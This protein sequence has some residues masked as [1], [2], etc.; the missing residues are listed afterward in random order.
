M[1]WA[2]LAEVLTEGIGS[3]PSAL[4]EEWAARRRRLAFD[5]AAAGHVDAAGHWSPA[6]RPPNRTRP[7]HSRPVPPAPSLQFREANS[8]PKASHERFRE[9]RMRAVA[10]LDR[11]PASEAGG[12]GFESRRVHRA[13]LSQSVAFS[14]S[15]GLPGLLRRPSL[16]RPSISGGWG[17]PAPA[18]GR[19]HPVPDACGQLVG[20]PGE[21]GGP[22]GWHGPAEVRGGGGVRF[23]PV[24]YPRARFRA[25]GLRGLSRGPTGR[26][27]M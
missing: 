27:L 8:N 9:Q 11:V 14:G 23:P 15:R 20:V 5:G 26:L 25:P 12:S 22:D 7:G 2:L 10:H 4:L 17:L 24:R 1:N 19:D 18:T 16:H 21:H 3:S 13:G 6:P